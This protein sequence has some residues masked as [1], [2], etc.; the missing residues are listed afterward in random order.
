LALLSQ[1]SVDQAARVVGIAPKTLLRWLQ[2]TEFQ[3]AY[4][5]ARREAVGQATARLQQGS[6]AAAS[7]LLR[8]MV[9]KDAPTSSRLRAAESILNHAAK[10]IEIEDIAARLAAL[11]EATQMLGQ[12]R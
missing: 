3:A 5:K 8:I 2:V 10:A 11:E 7:T 9:D 12:K 6:G 4:R 1:P